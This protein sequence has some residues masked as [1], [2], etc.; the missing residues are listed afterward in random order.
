MF[1][2]SKREIRTRALQYVGDAK[3]GATGNGGTYPQLRLPR[4]YAHLTRKRAHLFRS[5]KTAKLH[6]LFRQVTV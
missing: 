2:M 6:S 4:T 1:N 5:C 3:I